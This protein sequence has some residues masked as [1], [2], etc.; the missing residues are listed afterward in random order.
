MLSKLQKAAEFGSKRSVPIRVAEAIQQVIADNRIPAGQKIPSERALALALNASRASVRE[1]ISMLE[2]LGYLRVEVGRGAFVAE[3]KE[4]L[5]QDRWRFSTQCSLKEVYEYRRAVEPAAL[6]MAFNHFTA[7]DLAA[8]RAASEALAEHARECNSVKAAEQ[9]TIFHSMIYDLCGNRIFQEM[10]DVMEE[11]IRGSQ[12]VPMVIVEMMNDTAEEHMRI[13][14]A[15][16]A[17]NVTEAC[18]AL[19]HHIDR[20]AFRCGIPSL[21]S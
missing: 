6:A 1:G 17:G 18:A 16:E 13:V 19:V 5:P 21:T 7:S 14:E 3:P 2:T 10:H 9:D 12:W 11:A 8:L 20:A 15:L 4:F